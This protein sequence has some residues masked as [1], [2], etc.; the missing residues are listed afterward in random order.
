MGVAAKNS[1]CHVCAGVVREFVD[2]GSQPLSDAFVQ[3]GDPAGDFRF[4]L[5]VGV[6]ESC[7]MVQLMSEV[8]RDRMFHHD[9]PYLSSGSRFMREHFAALAEKLRREELT[10]PAPFVVEIGCN[11]GVMLESFAADGVHHLGV[12]PS[13]GVAERAAAKGVR[14]RNTFFDEP[15]AVEI[16]AEHGPADVVFA[17]NTLCHIPYIGSI[18]R[19]VAAL[20]SPGGVFVFEDPYFADIVERNSFDQI[21]DEHFFF[22]TVRSVQHMALMHGLELVDVERLPVHGGEL[23]YTL[24]RKGTRAVSLAVTDLAAQEERSGLTSPETLAGFASNVARIRTDLVELLRSLRAE[25]KTVVGYG[26]T[27]K[28]ATVLNFCGIGPELI[29]FICDTSVTKQGRVT[30]GS[31]IPVRPPDAFAD[32]YPDYAVLFAWNH[33]EE[34]LAKEIGFRESGGRWIRYV[35][36]VHI[37]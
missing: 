11:D 30:P 19:G 36:D 1:V 26:A 34:I 18:L 14:V 9:Y 22:F 3:P 31:H 29:P 24:A 4:R 16:L 13:G 21:Y 28:S 23:R 33:A 10:G 15:T 17:A 5:A 7:T 25:G 32:P 37:V 20:L 12:E 6:C 8:P 2:F 27:A 35:P